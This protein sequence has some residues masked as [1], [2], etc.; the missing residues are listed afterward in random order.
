MDVERMWGQ[1]G[2][3]EMRF[4]RFDDPSARIRGTRIK[5][6]GDRRRVEKGERQCLNTASLLR[7][8]I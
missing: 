2:C 6:G 4:T 7:V 8:L 1:V 5:G 3:A